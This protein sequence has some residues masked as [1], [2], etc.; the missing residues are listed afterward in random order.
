MNHFELGIR[1][2]FY[3]YLHRFFTAR[4][5][6]L[7][8]IPHT[9][10]NRRLDFDQPQTFFQLTRKVRFHEANLALF[11]NVSGF[12]FLYSCVLLLMIKQQKPAHMQ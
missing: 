9:A 3:F 4:Q 5:V 7:R 8:A 10:K 2:S 11:G 12:H 1:Q 6:I